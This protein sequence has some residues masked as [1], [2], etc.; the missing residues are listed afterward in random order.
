MLWDLKISNIPL[1]DWLVKWQIKA[2][3][4]PPP[5]PKTK[6]Q[7]AKAQSTPLKPPTAK[8]NLK[9]PKK[10]SKKFPPKAEKKQISAIGCGLKEA[11]NR[12]KKMTKV[13]NKIKMSKKMRQK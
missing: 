6:T 1:P 10:L 4:T 3:E 2:K 11:Q 13:D 12:R 8:L 5:P 9:T 7:I